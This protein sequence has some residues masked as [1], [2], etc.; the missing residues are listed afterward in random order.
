MDVRW[1]EVVP[2]PGA[3][4]DTTNVTEIVGLMGELWWAVVSGGKS[5]GGADIVQM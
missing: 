2:D 4:A 1:F 5:C 3:D